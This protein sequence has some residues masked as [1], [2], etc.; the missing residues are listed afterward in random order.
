MNSYVLDNVT[1]EHVLWQNQDPVRPHLDVNFKMS[2]GRGVFGL[3]HKGADDYKAFLCWAKT[4]AVPESEEDLD[5]LTSESGR[6]IVP[7]TVW[8]HERGAGREIINMVLK[9]VQDNK[10][11]DRVVTLSPPTVMAKKFHLRNSAILINSNEKIVNF[12]YNI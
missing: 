3:K 5:V 1:T 10:L 8:S 12:E 2:K 6:I 9:Y 7:Y 11:G 4:T